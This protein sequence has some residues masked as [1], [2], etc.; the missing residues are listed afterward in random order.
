MYGQ[1]GADGAGEQA[2][3]RGRRRPAATPR[4]DEGTVEGEFREV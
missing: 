3:R 1:P 2:R 4:R